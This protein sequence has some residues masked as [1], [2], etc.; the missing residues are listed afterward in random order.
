MEIAAYRFCWIMQ[1]EPL[2]S[3]LVVFV[4]L[5]IYLLLP[6]HGGDITT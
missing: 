3:V 1:I 6:V 2:C 5:T 4:T